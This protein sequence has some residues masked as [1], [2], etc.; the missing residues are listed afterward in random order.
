M[1]AIGALNGLNGRHLSART[2]VVNCSRVAIEGLCKFCF[3]NQ[4]AELTER[5]MIFEWIR[6]G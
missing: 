1:V 3:N 6:R 2:V 5:Y 4:L